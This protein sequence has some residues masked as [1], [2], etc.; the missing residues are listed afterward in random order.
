MNNREETEVR[1]DLSDQIKEA[2]R[3]ARR[4]LAE[5]IAADF[6]HE[7]PGLA[8]HK[9]RVLNR[10]QEAMHRAV[11]AERQ[12]VRQQLVREMARVLLQAIEHVGDRNLGRVLP[13]GRS[14]TPHWTD[15]LEEEQEG[16]Y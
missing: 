7:F 5:E 11:Q 8:K 3:S 6:V 15:L 16:G 1:G 4:M 9:V 12:Y 10:L 13:A 14:Y 2:R